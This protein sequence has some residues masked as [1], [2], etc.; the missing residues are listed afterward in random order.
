MTTRT[1]AAATWWVCGGLSLLGGVRGLVKPNELNE[2]SHYWNAGLYQ[3]GG[4]V[5][6]V[7]V[8]ALLIALGLYTFKAKDPADAPG[9]LQFSNETDIPLAPP[10]AG[11]LLIIAMTAVNSAPGYLGEH[12]VVLDQ[13]GL[14]PVLALMFGGG[15]WV[16]LHYRRL[17]LF[18][19]AAGTVKIH[20]GQPWSLWV[21]R[22]SFT[23]YE[24]VVVEKIE[25]RRMTVFRIVAQGQ[26]GSLLL[27]F[28]FNAESAQRDVDQVVQVT[29]WRADSAS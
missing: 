5:A 11:F 15:A 25:R 13:L 22:A 9:E 27:T 1:G 24:R 20:F 18:N 4:A 7:V 8:G 6:A 2:Y 29:G 10:M 16:L 21:K 28:T 17:T 19:R 23:D 3:Y 14:V 12:G 26:K